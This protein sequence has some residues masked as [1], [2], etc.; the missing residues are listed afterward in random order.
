MSF[1]SFLD[2]LGKKYNDL[3]DRYWEEHYE[4][5]L[6][7]TK[8]P[9]PTPG[10]NISEE[11]KTERPAPQVEI[12]AKEEEPK[13]ISSTLERTPYTPPKKEKKA[14]PR[15]KPT[16]KKKQIVAAKPTAPKSPTLNKAYGTNDVFSADFMTY[17]RQRRNRKG[18]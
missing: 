10:S 12:K 16:P 4:N 5:K 2:R 17:M 15:K 7:D 18:L 9:E 13:L 8:L 1:W 11:A 6:I 14:K 3:I